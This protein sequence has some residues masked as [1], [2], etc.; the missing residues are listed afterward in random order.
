VLK[1]DLKQG[2][3]WQ[4]DP[5]ADG[6]IITNPVAEQLDKEVGDSVVLSLGGKSYERQIIGIDKFP[7]SFVFIKWQELA[8]M[9]GFVDGEN[10]PLPGNF[11]VTLDGD[12]TVDE[13]DNK[14][15]EMSDLLAANSI[16][17]TYVNQP[18]AA[19]TEAQGITTFNVLLNMTSAV[20][21]A[22]GAIGLLATLSMAVFERQKEIGVMRSIGAGSSTIVV[23]FLVEGVL[24]GLIAWVVALPISFLLGMILND[25]L[26]FSDIFTYEYQPVVAVIGLVGVA[27]IAA[28]ASIWPSIAA[29]RRTVSEILRY[30]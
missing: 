21:A 4:R 10:N 16:Q 20:M 5:E 24:I 19:E 12:P 22:V 17:A 3:D 7:V 27:I 13:V 11:Y 28:V 14:I 1:L 15:S 18:E 2:T 26:G 8:E 23:Q 9:G 29:A 30:Q 6:V 25:S